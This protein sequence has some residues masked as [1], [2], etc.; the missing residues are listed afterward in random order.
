V[1]APTRKERAARLRAAGAAAV[2]RF[3]EGQVGTRAR[4]LVEQDGFGRTEHFAPVEVAGA[5]AGQIVPVHMTGLAG[6][7]LLGSLAA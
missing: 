6:E 2:G 3:L 5:A 1:P 4:V 7:R